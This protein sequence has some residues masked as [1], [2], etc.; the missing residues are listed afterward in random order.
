MGLPSEERSNS[1]KKASVITSESVMRAADTNV[2][3]RMLTRDD[4]GQAAAAD[5]FVAQGVWISILALAEAMWVLG[6][7]YGVDSKG[8]A[9]TI[10]LLL[11]HEHL[12]LQEPD[13]IAVALRLF[14]TQRALGFSDCLLMEIA[15]KAGHM[16]LGTFDRALGKVPGADL[17]R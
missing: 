14:R 8:I 3:I 6:K 5:E 2:L 12:V 10:D 9:K 15:R 1:S 7:V 4:P 16:P 11:A 17:L 13:V